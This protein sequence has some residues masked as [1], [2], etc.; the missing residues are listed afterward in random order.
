MNTLLEKLYN[1][2]TLAEE[3]DTAME[4]FFRR[5]E[6]LSGIFYL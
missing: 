2:N 1:E 6:Q 4:Y 3:V 5:E